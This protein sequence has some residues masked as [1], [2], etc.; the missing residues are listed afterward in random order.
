MTDAGCLQFPWHA[1]L[2]DVGAGVMV[3]GPQGA[4][5]PLAGSVKPMTGARSLR[6]F[7]VEVRDGRN[8]AGRLSDGLAS[9]ASRLGSRPRDHVTNV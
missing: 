7:P 2:Y 3:R 9:S 8:L 1:A 4:F 6:R 5:K